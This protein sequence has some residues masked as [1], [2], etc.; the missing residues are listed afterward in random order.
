[1]APGAAP[2]GDFHRSGY[3][4]DIG[5]TAK[6][7]PDSSAFRRGPELALVVSAAER[8]AVHDEPESG[9]ENSRS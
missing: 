9:H 3:R 2:P 5:G 4:V 7:S 8:P 6:S 1:V